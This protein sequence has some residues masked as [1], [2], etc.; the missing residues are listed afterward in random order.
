MERQ[1]VVRGVNHD[2]IGSMVSGIRNA[3]LG[4]CRQNRVFDGFMKKSNERM[5]S[6]SVRYFLCQEGSKKNSVLFLIDLKS[7]LCHEIL[8]NIA[9]YLLTTR[10]LS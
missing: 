7:I 2:F 6:I 10:V 8:D 1:A 9:L 5:L 3:V 4:S